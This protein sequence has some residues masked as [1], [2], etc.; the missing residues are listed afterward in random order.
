MKEAQKIHGIVLAGGKSKRMGTT[1]GL[2]LLNELPFI[3]YSI[4]ALEP[5]TSERYVVSDDAAYNQL[6]CIR[7]N[8]LIKDSGPLGGLYSGLSK[9]SSFY[10]LVLS[11]DV[12]FITTDLLSLLI[13]GIEENI[14]VIQFSCEDRTHPL[15]ALYTKECIPSFKDLLQSGERRLRVALA[16]VRVKTIS[17]KPE[18]APLLQNINT[19]AE[20]EA[21][22]N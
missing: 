2:L 9:S 1:K 10:N 17:L 20:Y 21:I 22:Q 13:D 6:P 19:R 12:P 18:F 11:C 14:D 7:V 3:S 15:I 5:L 8:D 16:S 4:R